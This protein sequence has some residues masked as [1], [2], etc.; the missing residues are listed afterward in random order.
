VLLITHQSK[1][2]VKAIRA[3]WRLTHL[4]ERLQHGVGHAAL[5]A[6]Q[7]P[8]LQRRRMLQSLLLLFCDA[9]QSC[10]HNMTQ[11]LQPHSLRICMAPRA[12]Q[13]GE[14]QTTSAATSFLPPRY[15][16]PSPFRR[17]R[18]RGSLRRRGLAWEQCKNYT[19]TLS[20]LHERGAERS[21][22][23]SP[24]TPL[25]AN[26]DGGRSPKVAM[27]RA[28]WCINPLQE[29][30]GSSPNPAPPLRPSAE[31]GRSPTPSPPAG[32][33]LNCG[34]SWYSVRWSSGGGSFTPVPAVEW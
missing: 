12:V 2:A 15:S 9:V 22:P 25:R 21:Q 26:A 20:P 1:R 16:L 19:R 34:R 14:A 7:S 18:A 6:L 17:T 11:L 4:R 13:L 24:A 5:Q 33:W 29:H 10:M 3:I 27:G 8:T 30:A 28:K 32:G 23:W 31:G